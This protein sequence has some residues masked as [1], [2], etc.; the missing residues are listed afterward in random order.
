[1]FR[2]YSSRQILLLGII[3]CVFPGKPLLTQSLTEDDK[4]Y[5]LGRL[6]AGA[7]DVSLSAEELMNSSSDVLRAADRLK[8]KQSCAMD[9]ELIGLGSVLQKAAS[10]LERLKPA[11]LEQHDVRVGDLVKPDPAAKNAIA[12]NWRRSK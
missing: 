5:L 4:N 6:P 1:V 10:V 2:T 7:E 8:Q 11:L 9:R 3:V 12:E